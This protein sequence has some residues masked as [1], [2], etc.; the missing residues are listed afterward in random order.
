M[1]ERNLS[2][3]SVA[4]LGFGPSNF[5]GAGNAHAQYLKSLSRVGA[6]VTAWFVGEPFRERELVDAGVTVRPAL[7]VVSDAYGESDALKYA[8]IADEI[9]SHAHSIWLQS[10]ATKIIL[11]GTYLVPFCSALSM[12]AN[13]LDG[14]GIPVSFVVVPAGSDIWQIAPQIPLLTQNLLYGDHVSHRVTYS[15]PF[16]GEVAA[17]F[18]HSD[19]FLAICPSV[20]INRFRPMSADER[21]KHREQL[22][23]LEDEIVLVTI[24][25]NRP[26]KK[27]DET[28]ALAREFAR[29]A[30]KRVCMLIVGPMTQHLQSALRENMGDNG[31]GDTTEI[32]FEN[33][34][35]FFAGLQR[36]VEKYHG[37][38]DIAINTSFH[39]SFNISL[40]ESLAC[41]V[42]VV[43]T[44]S[45]G[46][47]ELVQEFDAGFAFQLP[48]SRGRCVLG[49]N[50]D[51][52]SRYA[53]VVSWLQVYFVDQNIRLQKSA[54]ARILAIDALSE[55]IADDKWARLLRSSALR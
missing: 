20:D 50:T 36:N 35:V 1:D 55:G 8:S 41:G 48:P 28:I 34:R 46:I 16:A 30:K 25:N 39:D 5:A 18:A 19:D 2:I 43:T 11:L 33:G 49:A 53:V 12:A 13:I 38:A 17:M 45:T 54:N 40:G 47:A 51:S 22:G 10:P 14:L 23:I 32:A 29:G 26:V 42:P 7:S 27:L 44:A 15:K 31:S 6:K 24:S 52:S 4:V 3:D 37:I 21:T 9:A